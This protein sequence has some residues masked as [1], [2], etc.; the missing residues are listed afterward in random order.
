MKAQDFSKPI[1]PAAYGQLILDLAGKRGVS[2]EPL[3]QGLNIPAGLLEKSTARLTQG[4]ISQLLYRAMKLTQDPALGYEIGL[5]SNLT[6]HGFI[7]YGVLSS[8]TLREAIE[9]GIK[10]VQLRLPLLSMRL[11]TEK[12]RGVIEVVERVPLGLLRQC[13][14]D[15]F[16]VGISRMVPM[17]TGAEQMPNSGIELRFDYPE[18]AYYAAYRERLPPTRFSQSAN[19]MCFPARYLDRVLETANQETVQLVTE[20]CERELALLGHSRDLLSSVR[21]ALV[22]E[23]SGYPDLE[24]VA[25]RLSTS[26]RTLKRKLQQHQLSFQQLLDEARKRDSIRLLQDPTLSLEKIANRIGYADPANFTRAFRKW[27]GFAPSRF[28][29][30]MEQKDGR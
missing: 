15:L 20:R 18:P 21:A 12:D 5:N 3:L 24:A 25:Q 29:A 27:T 13:T 8:S 1:V 22:N 2:R 23:R 7:G 30:Q 26:S 19:Q 16:L 14:F 11:F 17:R 4:Q 28:R 9:F 6:S 10:F